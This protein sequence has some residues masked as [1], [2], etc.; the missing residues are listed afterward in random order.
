MYSVEKTRSLNFFKHFDFVLLISVLLLSI[1]GL[2]AISSATKSS[3]DGSGMV[4]KQAVCIALGIIIAFTLSVIDYK[5]F[6]ILG[7]ILYSISLVL[8][9]YVLFK[10]VGGKNYGSNSWILLPFGQQF[11]PA[12]LAK[13]TFIIVLSI[14]FEKL[15][16]KRV[17]KNILIIALLSILPIG[18]VVLQQDFGT[19]MVF[20]FIMFVLLFAYGLRYR[21]L[22]A[23]M[24]M[25]IPISLFAWFYVLNGARK[26]RI[27]IFLNP[28]LDPQITGYQMIQA[29]RAIGSGQM[30]GKGLFNGV[31]TVPEQKNDMIFTVIGE[32]LGFIGAVIIITLIFFMLFR[33]IYIAKNSRDLFGSYLIIGLTGMMGFHFLEN[34][35]ANLGLLPLTGIPLPFISYGGTAMITNYLAIG[36]MLSVSMRRKRTIFNSD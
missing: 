15:K 34:I 25:S 28:Q 21:Y 14:Y 22:I 32:Q 16:E 6:K 26:A 33:C 18:L 17:L 24:V 29:K 19:A 27:L 35:G 10:G 9:V 30:Y 4:I 11:Q 20:V 23:A 7:L 2:L 13:I 1:I 5:D 31:T 36:I 12:E 8:L 3:P